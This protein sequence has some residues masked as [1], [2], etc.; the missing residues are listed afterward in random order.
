MHVVFYSVSPFV[1]TGFAFAG[2]G[3]TMALL[4]TRTRTIFMP[5]ENPTGRWVD[6]TA[7]IL[8]TMFFLLAV[9]TTAR[10]RL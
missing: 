9:F 4:W 1:L 10:E 5:K 2:V 6:V 3:Y 8:A 7:T